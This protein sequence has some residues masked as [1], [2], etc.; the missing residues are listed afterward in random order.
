MSERI[1]DRIAQ[2]K[3]DTGEQIE[4]TFSDTVRRLRQ[5]ADRIER[6]LAEGGRRLG[7]AVEEAGDRASDYTRRMR[8]SYY[9]RGEQFDVRTLVGLAAIAGLGYV[10]YRWLRQ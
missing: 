10:A 4:E 8:R 5:T 2:F 1:V 7:D 3:E 9:R 6:S